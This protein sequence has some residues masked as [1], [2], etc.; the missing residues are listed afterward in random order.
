MATS[1]LHMDLVELKNVSRE[2]T[3]IADDLERARRLAERELPTVA[4][5]R[6]EVS[7]TVAH[8][9]ESVTRAHCSAAGRVVADLRLSAR[10]LADHGELVQAR[11]A[12][13]AGR[14]STGS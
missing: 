9:I 1:T 5:G 14:L 11:D 10:A 8:T 12:D 7:T 4:S 6:D 2:L 13:L 3:R